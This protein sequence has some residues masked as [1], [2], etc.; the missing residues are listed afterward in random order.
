MAHYTENLAFL[1]EYKRNPDK[2]LPLIDHAWKVFPDRSEY[3]EVN[4]G[5]NAGIVEGNRPFF[6]ECWAEGI[7]VLTYFISTKGIEEYS[8]EQIEKMLADAEIIWYVGERKYPTSV[9]KF[10][11]HEG[12]EFFS[13]NIIVGDDDGTYIEGGVIYG[14]NR[15]NEYNSKAEE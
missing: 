11:D 6:C 8:V 14:M 13:I 7:T 2:Y 5:W 10:T 9:Q 1:D 3:G 4:V 15:L 12:N